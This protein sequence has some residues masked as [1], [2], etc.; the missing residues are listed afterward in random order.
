MYA[1][2]VNDG[3]MSSHVE[4]YAN[5]DMYAKPDLVLMAT[6][7]TSTMW[8]CGVQPVFSD[9]LNLDFEC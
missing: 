1:S 3:H 6:R 8:H 5:S 4:M 2:H 7:P 9:V